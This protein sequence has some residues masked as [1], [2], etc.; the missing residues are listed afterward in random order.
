[1]C[2]NP[3][4]HPNCVKECIKPP[5]AAQIH[6]LTAVKQAQTPTGKKEKS[7]PARIA[8]LPGDQPRHETLIEPRISGNLGL[9]PASLADHLVGL[10]SPSE[11]LWPCLAEAGLLLTPLA[12]VG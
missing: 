7:I 3:T 5:F 10:L 9:V 11:A 6:G 1:M 8:S 2:S 4:V 12:L